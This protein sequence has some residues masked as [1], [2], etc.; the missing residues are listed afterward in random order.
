[1]KC[2][3]DLITP[4]TIW[5][6]FDVFY[7]CNMCHIPNYYSI[8][9][10]LS[11]IFWICWSDDNVSQDEKEACSVTDESPGLSLHTGC[12]DGKKRAGEAAGQPPGWGH[13]P[14]GSSSGRSSLTPEP[15]FYTLGSEDCC[16]LCH[17]LTFDTSSLIGL[18][19][20]LIVDFYYLDII[21]K[22]QF[23]F[24]PSLVYG[25]TKY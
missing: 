14:D 15:A 2:V 21:T 4:P 8:P 6:Q 3:A 19:Y 5:K 10:L 23:N 9:H 13:T 16:L 7:K 12:F 18:F 25:I 24:S 11:H 17:W 22:L 20:I 1:M